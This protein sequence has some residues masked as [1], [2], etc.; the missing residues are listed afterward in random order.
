MASPGPRRAPDATALVDLDRVIHEPCRLAIL[1]A[2]AV[3]GTLGFVELRQMLE[4]SDGN[5]S[6]HARRLEDAGYVERR[7]DG[8][9]APRRTAYRLTPA[10]HAA[11]LRYLAHIEALT[12]AARARGKRRFPR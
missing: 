5:L 10:G 6:V 4:L 9:G 11:F 2:L 7:R 12:G 3:S 8:N 1:S